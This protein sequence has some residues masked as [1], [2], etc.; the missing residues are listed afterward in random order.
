M[1]SSVDQFLTS[2]SGSVQSD[3]YLHDFET[4]T[5]TILS[6]TDSEAV[7]QATAL[8]ADGSFAALGLDRQYWGIGTGL[9]PRLAPEGLF[10]PGR[11][12]GGYASDPVNTATGNFT[13]TTID[14]AGSVAVHGVEVSRTYNALDDG[15]TSLGRGWRLGYDANLD[16]A[17]GQSVEMVDHDGRRITFEWDG[18]GWDRPEE[19]FGDLVDD[20]DGTLSIEYFDGEVWEFD[21]TGRLARLSDSSGQSVDLVRDGAGLLQ[22]A[23][24]S[25]GAALSFTYALGRLES[26]TTDDGR[27]VSYT[28]NAAGDLTEVTH[29]DGGTTEYDVDPDGRIV[30]HRDQGGRLVVANEYDTEG[31]IRQQTGPNGAVA[32]FTYNPDGTTTVSN[33]GNGTVTTYHHDDA[34]RLTSI[35]DPFGAVMS[36]TYDDDGNLTAAVD[37]N[38]NGFSQLYDDHGNVTQTT[39][40]AGAVSSTAYDSLDRPISYTDDTGTT[41]FVYAGSERTPTEIIGV[42]D[43]PLSLGIT[44]GLIESMTD[45]DGV[46]RTMAYDA[47]RN[48]T[49]VTNGAGETTTYT[50]DGAGRRLTETTPLGHTTTYTYD[51]MGRV[52]SV[53]DPTGALTT[54][55]YDTSG[56]V[57]TLT[58]PA[59]GVTTNTYDPAGNLATVTDALGGV[60]SYTYDSQGNQLTESRPG[61]A[62]TTHSYD[63][64]NRLIATTDPT[65]VVTEFTHDDEGNVTAVT[66]SDDE[67]WVTVHDGRDRIVSETDPL[68]NTTAYTYDDQ[69]RITSVT[70][71]LDETTTYVYDQ[72]G[73][74]TSTHHPDGGVATATYSPAGRLLTETDPLG[75]T[76]SHGYDA[77]GRLASVTKP[78]G[79]TTTTVYDDDGRTTTQISPTGRTTQYTHDPAGRVLSSTGPDGATTIFT[80]TAR[81]ETATVTDSLSALT[82]YTW[83]LLSRLD[84][85]T[86]PNGGVTGH[87]YDGRGNRTTRTD[88]NGNAESWT[89]DLAD[90]LLSHTDKLGET[91]TFAYDILGRLAST[92]DAAGLTETIGY[93]GADRPITHTYGDGTA[94][95]TGYDA[96]GRRTSSSGPEGTTNFTLDAMGRVLTDAGPNGTLA[97]TYD[98]AGRRTSMSYPDGTTTAY[99]YDP[100]GRL[101]S[102]DHPDL[103]VATYDF[104]LDGYLL[105]ENLPGGSYRSYALDQAGRTVDFTQVL[106]GT[107]RYRPTYDTNGQVTALAVGSIGGSD[108]EAYTYDPAGQLLSATRG[109]AGT[110][111]DRTHTYDA[112]GNV[113]SQTRG[114]ATD[115]YTTNAGDQLV[116]DLR[117]GTTAWN[118]SYDDAGR[119]VERKRNNNNY[120]ST[121]YDARGLPDTITT[122]AGSGNPT[123]ETRTY[124]TDKLLSAVSYT[125]PDGTSRNYELRWDR[126]RDIPE[127]A[128]ISI[129]GTEHQV[130]AGLGELGT[131]DSTGQA[132]LFSRDAFGS[133]LKTTATSHL[134]RAT[135]FFASGEPAAGHAN[136]QAPSLGYRG[137][138][139]LGESLHLRARDLEVRVGRFTTKDPLDG[140]PGMTT[141]TNLYHYVDNAPTN[142]VDPLGT[143]SVT[144]DEIRWQTDPYVEAANALLNGW[145][146]TT[147]VEVGAMAGPVLRLGGYSDDY[148]QLV[149]HWQLSWFAQIDSLRVD[150]RPYVR[151]LA[152]AGAIDVDL[153]AA[154][155][156][157][158]ES[159][160]ST[161][162]EAPAR[163]GGISGWIHGGLDVAGLIP[164]IGEVA[165]LLNAGYYLV[166]G[167]GLNAG[168]SAAGL[169]PFLGQGATS[170][171]LAGR[172]SNASRVA[173]LDV[174]TYGDLA[175]RSVG[176]GLT[177]D[178]VPSFAAVRR[179]VE[180]SLGREL[181]PDEVRHLRNNTNC[182][183]VCTQRH[184]AASRTF[185]GRNSPAQI[186]SDAADLGA[187]ARRD[188]AEL[189]R[190]LLQRGFSR[191]HIDRAFERLHQ[192]NRQD[193]R[194]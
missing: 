51:A 161:F 103:G 93:D 23:V 102:V 5:T 118:Y 4:R 112:V 26:V 128:S 148:V 3:V 104:D 109:A 168:I 131:V 32:T 84:T 70:D 66:N 127:L 71:P 62:V 123:V 169:I 56:R 33:S 177:P 166:E 121:T 11:R 21:T 36:K 114:T 64:L 171:R 125:D 8:S 98:L 10:G 119:E 46:V 194:Y 185:G 157:I 181:R 87:T 17:V 122:K 6:A 133:I 37:R 129:D 106:S 75:H 78:D 20:G 55:T 150:V 167:D 101:T 124:D 165:D 154:L 153:F 47:R 142:R 190:D 86:D 134:T 65:G 100:V 151:A 19:M 149:N 178:H 136:Q 155:F 34:G 43:E 137:E 80:Y 31:R 42:D 59:G 92:T 27:T 156:S 188:L 30:E 18:A 140:K 191:H 107:K 50:Y 159:V 41:E 60:T 74:L 108:D 97:Y 180:E 95:T 117:S 111:D 158:T 67:S 175:R 63:G 162:P 174:G 192:L 89:Y 90:R 72:A 14:V 173:E 83:D 172:V 28:Y 152:S 52:T 163:R 48:L 144:D 91:T 12:S 39:D 35:V 115:T 113:A 45:A 183:V 187:A 73:N 29:P 40:Q 69:D 57:L 138:L 135:R 120:V 1:F 193:G 130:I 110:G 54:T 79:G 126:T 88:A 16:G 182:V 143:S 15:A 7:W 61:G 94:I 44:N 170:L 25:T 81:G 53:T 189:R 184:Q 105:R 99:G 2:P 147:R 85:V 116:T 49:S 139:H 160:A 164:A 22:S 96:A 24:S 82:Q 38:T 9:S 132:A 186:A 13:T 58:D 76:T 146:E 179:N 176:D 77:A 145:W 141:L 68:G